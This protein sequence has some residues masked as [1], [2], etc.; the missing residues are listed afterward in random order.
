M[1]RGSGLPIFVL[2]LMVIIGFGVLV[3]SNAQPTPE[4][5]VIVP[6]EA[7]PTAADNA[8][9]TILREGFGSESTP[10][11]TLAIPTAAFVPPTLPPASQIELT[12]FAPQNASLNDPAPTL[13]ASTPT[14]ASSS[15]TPLA[16]NIPLTVLPVTRVAQDFQPPPLIPP[17]SRD[18]FGRDHFWLRRPVDSSAL[19]NGGLFYYAYGSDGP[20]NAWRIHAGIDMPNP[21]GETVRAAGDGVVEWANENFQSTYTYG[22]TVFIRHDFGYDGQPIYTLYAHLATILVFPGQTVQEGDAI[23]LVGNTGRVS[24]PH[25]HFEVRVGA[26]DYGSTYNPLLWMVPYV[27]TG[28]IAGRVVDR[29]NDLAMDVD[30]TVRSRATGLVVDTTTTYIYRG[31]AVDVNP[32]PSWGEN[33]VI[34]D[35]AV[36]RYD[37]IATVNGERITTTVDVLEGTTSFAELS[38]FAPQ[39]GS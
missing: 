37:V 21:I 27:N 6:T 31:T 5:R 38:L 4:L 18:P 10:I 13:A 9:Q 26:D 35:I 20:E 39:E 7:Q 24:G 15:P 17:L 19:N 8:W 30:V 28:V 34:S 29:N 25:V 1:Q 2:V 11:P 36:G 32:D 33:F 23:G 22:K 16:T 14:R 3:Y 12:P